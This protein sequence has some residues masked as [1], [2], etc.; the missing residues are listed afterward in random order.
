MPLNPPEIKASIFTEAQRSE[1]LRLKSYFPFRIVW[2]AVS[3]N[4]E[5]VCGA[6]KDRRQVN[7]Y[8]RLQ[9]WLVCTIN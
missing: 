8:A 2:G 7:K 5:F 4:G 3:V 1:L 6:S 9:D